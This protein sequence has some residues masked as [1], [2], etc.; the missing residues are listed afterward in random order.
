VHPE[1]N[2]LTNRFRKYNYPFFECQRL[3]ISMLEGGPAVT[4]L[5]A[6]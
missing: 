4:P 6:V 3:F 5:P 2:R 1:L